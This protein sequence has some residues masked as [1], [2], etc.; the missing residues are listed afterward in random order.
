MISEFSPRFRGE[1]PS[2][3]T[4]ASIRA[5]G[6]GIS[7]KNP[8]GAGGSGAQRAGPDLGLS[9]DGERGHA[10]RIDRLDADLRA[11]RERE[12]LRAGWMNAGSQSVTANPSRGTGASIRARGSGI[13]RKNTERRLWIL[14]RKRVRAPISA[15]SGDGERGHAGP[16]AR[17]D[18]LQP[19]GEP[20]KPP[21]PPFTPN[22]SKHPRKG[23]VS[24]KHH[25]TPPSK[26]PRPPQ[27]HTPHPLERT[28][29]R[30]TALLTHHRRTH[31][32][33]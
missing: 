19:G 23:G 14:G 24:A 7:R 13:S 20:K 25:A 18:H 5:R 33:T 2:E 26:P 21:P 22:E 6:S 30:G 12:G 1:S 11:A 29:A 10:G 15:F 28:D 32:R 17:R 31:P 16:S 27:E 8:R 4:G 3:R 9:G